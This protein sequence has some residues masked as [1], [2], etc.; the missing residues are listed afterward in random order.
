M[1]RY[2]FFCASNQ[3]RRASRNAPMPAKQPLPTSE[4]AANCVRPAHG[5]SPGRKTTAYSGG[6]LVPLFSTF[7][8]MP[9]AV[10]CGTAFAGA[11]YSGA[12]CACVEGAP[13]KAT[14]TKRIEQARV[15]IGGG[16]KAASSESHRSAEG[17]WSALKNL[18]YD[19]AH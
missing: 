8:H 15:F 16:S 11:T 10:P 1:A 2:I 9:G 6:P 4:S 3:P 12:A 14:M 19:S 7:T 5:S 13:A 18:S 17:G